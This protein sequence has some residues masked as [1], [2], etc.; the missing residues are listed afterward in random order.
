MTYQDE[1]RSRHRFYTLTI[2]IIGLF[3]FLAGIAAWEALNTGIQ[4]ERLTYP[5]HTA[6]PRD[7][8]ASPIVIYF[9]P[10][11]TPMYRKAY[12]DS[13]LEVWMDWKTKTYL[14][15]ASAWYYDPNTGKEY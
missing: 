10:L 15:P 12:Y 6:P 8:E 5:G 7:G 14:P 3:C 4:E 2:L 1:R 9:H 13:R 11:L